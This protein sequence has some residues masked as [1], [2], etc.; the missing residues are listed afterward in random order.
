M[1]L[2]VTSAARDGDLLSGEKT[3]IDCLQHSQPRF[4]IPLI[5]RNAWCAMGSLEHC[6]AT[7]AVAAARACAMSDERANALASVHG[8]AEQVAQTPTSVPQAQNSITVQSSSADR[9]DRRRALEDELLKVQQ[10][11]VEVRARQLD[12]RKRELSLRANPRFIDP[13]I[14]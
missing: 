13:A 5:N 1:T 11:L 2:S 10:Q 14:E 8:Q 7:K 4:M 6:E 3:N 9:R 12:L